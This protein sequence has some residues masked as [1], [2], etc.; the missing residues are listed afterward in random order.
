MDAE[1]ELERIKNY[2]ANSLNNYVGNTQTTTEDVKVMTER[3]LRLK[4][5]EDS[6]HIQ[7]ECTFTKDGRDIAVHPMNLF[8][9]IAMVGPEPLPSYNEVKDLTSW[10]GQ[11]GEYELKDGDMLFRPNAPL[12]YVEVN[13]NI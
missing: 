13:I 11:Y 12:E 5:N 2:I 8:T 1:K 10:K 9:F 6:E 7:V 4:A 3:I